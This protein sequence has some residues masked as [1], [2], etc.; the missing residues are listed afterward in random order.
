MALSEQL[1]PGCSGASVLQCHCYRALQCHQ[2]PA[3]AVQKYSKST[4]L[5]RV[6]EGLASPCTP[7][8]PSGRSPPRRCLPELRELWELVKSLRRILD[9][10]NC[11]D[12]C[13][14]VT[15]LPH[16]AREEGERARHG[17]DGGD[18]CGLPE[19]R[20]KQL[21]AEQRIK[22]LQCPPLQYV[23]RRRCGVA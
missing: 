14:A 22:N 21:D 20:E 12:A 16:G 7:H 19:Y 5:R 6:R 1:V 11:K 2:Q 15:V 4:P 3:A 23:A 13:K 10:C 8:G 9:A 18:G 17:R